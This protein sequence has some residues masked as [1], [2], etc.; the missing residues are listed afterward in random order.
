MNSMT[1]FGKAEVANR[2]GKYVVEVSSVNNRFLEVLVRMPRYLSTLESKIRDLIST[3]VSR[4]K[5]NVYINVEESDLSPGKYQ[6]NKVA[7]K[8]YYLQL[9]DIQEELGL[10]GKIVLGDLMMLPDLANPEKE[11]VDEDG[12]WKTLEGVVSHALKRMLVMRRKEGLEMKRDMQQRLLTLSKHLKTVK[13]L[14]RDAVAIRR[15]KLTKR[16]NE[17]L[18]SPM[19]DSLRI[20]EE[21]A[22]FAEKADITEECTRLASHIKQ[23]RANLSLAEATG[24]KL[25]FILQEMNREANTIASKASDYQISSE[26]ISIKN[27]IEKIREL[28]QN[29]E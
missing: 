26:A 18:E 4:G 22:I 16:V 17:L 6:I 3:M 27:E 25:N 20:E 2:S 8:A 13:T 29:V 15:D 7:L 21:I 14:S 28:V 1:G 11:A 12:V 9:K 23:Y 24:K 10:G 5:V 19:R